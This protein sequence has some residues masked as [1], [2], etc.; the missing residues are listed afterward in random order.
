MWGFKKREGERLPLTGFGDPWEEGFI[1]CTTLNQMLCS[2]GLFP[3]LLSSSQNRTGN[4]YHTE[5]ECR[6][7][8]PLLASWSLLLMNPFPWIVRILNK[9]ISQEIESYIDKLRNYWHINIG[10]LEQKIFNNKSLEKKSMH[11]G[12]TKI[13]FYWKSKQKVQDTLE[14]SW[15]L[16]VIWLIR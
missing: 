10:T 1:R 16:N 15:S 7:I 13:K 12:K 4:P 14:T 9:L 2:G 5:Y 3:C 6:S 11:K 8:S